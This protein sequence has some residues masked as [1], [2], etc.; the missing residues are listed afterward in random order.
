MTTTFSLQIDNFIAKSKDVALAVVKD[1]SLELA[2]ESNIPTAKGGNLPVDTSFLRNSQRA[3]VNAVPSGPSDPETDAWS[4]GDADKFV[5]EA[6][7]SME[8]GQSLYI[9]WT[10]VYARKM[11]Y[12]G[13]GGQGYGYA[14]KAAQK[15][16][17]IVQQ[18]AAKVAK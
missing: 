13:K 17:Q 15:W 16:Q 9:G 6:I 3:A 1:A 14:R 4:P 11:E 5:P 7:L 18:S 2:R 12:I 10:A 8:L